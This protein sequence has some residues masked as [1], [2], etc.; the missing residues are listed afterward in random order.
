MSTE[1]HP[2]THGANGEPRHADVTFE[3]VDVQVSTIYWYLVALGVSVALSLLACVYIFRFTANLAQ[4]SNTPPTAAMRQMNEKMAHENKDPASMQYPDEPR[5]QGVPGHTADPQQD[6]RDKLEVDRKANDTL[7][8]I[9][10]NT[11]LAQIPV[12]DAMKIIVEKGL[13]PIASAEKKK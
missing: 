13:P 2:K 12:D 9:D 4:E 3:P 7:M 11:G 10:R 6:L 5:L 8:W 1:H